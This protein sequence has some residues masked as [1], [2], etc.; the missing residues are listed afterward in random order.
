MGQFY[1]VGAITR[2]GSTRMFSMNLTTVLC[3]TY[4]Q[5]VPHVCRHPVRWMDDF[6][7]VPASIWLIIEELLLHA[8]RSA[9][10]GVRGGGGGS[11]VRLA[12]VQQVVIDCA[13]HC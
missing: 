13:T 7:A 4:G 10:I 1:L 5:T 11:G 8:A 9:G 2:T 3:Q 6:L 12:L